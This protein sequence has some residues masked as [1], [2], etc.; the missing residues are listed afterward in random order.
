MDTIKDLLRLAWRGLLLRTD[1]YATMAETPSPFVRGLILIVIIGVLFSLT[2][3]VGTT[4]E[5][6]TTPNMGAIKEAVRQGLQ[7]MSWYRELSAEP[8]FVRQFS[9]GYD[10]WWQIFGS[11]F[12]P[13]PLGAVAG[14]ITNPF[15]LILGWLIYGLL[16]HVCARLL[17]GQA[18]IGQTYGA[19]ALSAAPQLLNLV[20]FIPY[21]EVGGVVGTWA[22]ICNFLALKTAHR[23]T[24]GRAV[25]ATILPFFVL[26][27]IAI[28]LGIL[29][30]L[31]AGA[32]LASLGGAR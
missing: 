18:S 2:G 13:S 7:E 26:F 30:V 32:L 17:G 25:W 28:V 20:N 5:W 14:I 11:M 31:A 4:L 22:L 12:T 27:V 16:A 24:T 6:L 10:L 8:E 21:V 29:G 3:I 23:L 19:T 1:A 15:T 9:Q